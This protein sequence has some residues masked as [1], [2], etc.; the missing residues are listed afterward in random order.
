M[1]N[2]KVRDAERKGLNEFDRWNDVTGVIPK[3]TSTYYELQGVIEDAVHIGI[4][5]ALNGEV[6]RNEHGEIVKPNK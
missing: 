4:Q 5:M 6:E 3:H 2:G 1:E